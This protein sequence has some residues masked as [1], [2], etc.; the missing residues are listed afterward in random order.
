MNRHLGIKTLLIKVSDDQQTSLTMLLDRFLETRKILVAPGL[1]VH[2]LPDG[3][4]IELYGPGASYPA[5]L[6]SHGHVVIGYKV[7]HIQET[8]E[9]LK[10]QGYKLQGEVIS[11][12]EDNCICFMEQD[13][14]LII[15]LYQLT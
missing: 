5:W 11:I 6:F 4:T 3:S 14:K 15:G 2:Q 1:T 12:Y 7:S 9:S 13:N 10:L 8:I